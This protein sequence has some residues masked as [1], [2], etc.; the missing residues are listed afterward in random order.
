MAMDAKENMVS[1]CCGAMYYSHHLVLY[2]NK[3]GK[4]CK[5]TNEKILEEC[6]SEREDDKRYVW[7]YFLVEV[8]SKNEVR[9]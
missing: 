4:K 7:H 9:K 1:D 3:C 5:I 8:R 6:N 2:C